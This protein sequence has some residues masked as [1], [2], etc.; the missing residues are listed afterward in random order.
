MDSGYKRKNC[1]KDV[2]VEQ[3]E[4]KIGKTV[5]T[6]LNCTYAHIEIIKWTIVA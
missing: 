5:Y 2:I 4:N 1:A 6:A 3:K